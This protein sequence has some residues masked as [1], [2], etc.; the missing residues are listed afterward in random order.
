MTVG[1]A[2]NK[3]KTLNMKNVTLKETLD[4]KEDE[5]DLPH[6]KIS[7]KNK[8]EHSGGGGGVVAESCPTVATPWTVACQVPLSVG[9]SRQ[10]C[11]R[12]LPFPSPGDRPDP[13]IEP[14]SLA[15]QAKSLPTEM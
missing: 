9:F 10:E 1:N 4:Q 3:I 6:Q 7:Y 2:K 5:T 13:G 15:L 11:W 8:L 12:R 14:R